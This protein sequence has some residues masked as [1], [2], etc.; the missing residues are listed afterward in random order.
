VQQAKPE[1]Q[2]KERKADWQNSEPLVD[3]L[4]VAGIN[5]PQDQARVAPSQK[6]LEAILEELRAEFT[7]N[8]F[9]ERQLRARAAQR[10]AEARAEAFDA[11]AR[12]SDSDARREQA[13]RERADACAEASSALARAADADARREQ[14]ERERADACA[15]ASS[16]L[17][18]AA[19]ADARREQAER[20]RD[21]ARAE[22]SSALARA[23]D[24]DARR[25]QAER[26]L[27]ELADRSLRL[28]SSL[29]EAA[30]TLNS[31]HK[32]GLFRLTRQRF[33]DWRHAKLI[34]NSPLFDAGWY[35][36]RYPEVETSGLDPAHE[37]LWNAALLGRNPGPG[38]DSSRYL[39]Q[40]TDV[41]QTGMNPLLHYI[42]FG[43]A[44]GRE[45]RPAD[46]QPTGRPSK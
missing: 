29:R 22:A 45:I 6:N 13:E 7:R 32:M 46:A 16:A 5:V 24:A 37:F 33:R 18:R 43:A 30:A 23:A 10:A 21:E 19:D 41:A 39:L 28:E 4:D 42:L 36:Q 2:L 12:A 44:E 17:A 14:A 11:L 15:E 25:E 38:F 40:H 3:K 27:A 8:S 1:G 26:E 31:L 35:V 34:R 9:A 20:E